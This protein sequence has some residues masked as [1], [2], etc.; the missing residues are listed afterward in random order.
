MLFTAP[1]RPTCADLDPLLPTACW[2]SEPQ[3]ELL[4]ARSR[5]SPRWLNWSSNKKPAST[6]TNRPYGISCRCFVSCKAS[7]LDSSL[8][9]NVVTGKPF[10]KMC[11]ILKQ[12]GLRFPF[13]ARH[14][15]F[16]AVVYF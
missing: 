12:T 6:S 1:G 9:R 10:V 7:E 15:C 13:D 2:P 11:N 16:V 8:T 5:L 3:S 4:G 14:R